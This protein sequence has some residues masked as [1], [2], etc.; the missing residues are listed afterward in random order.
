MSRKVCFLD[1]RDSSLNVGLNTPGCRGCCKSSNGVL[2]TSKSGFSGP[3]CVALLLF[4][5]DLR[6][7][8][9]THDTVNERTSSCGENAGINVL[10]IFPKRHSNQKALFSGC[11]PLE[12]R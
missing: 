11:A 12:V 8:V 3:Q 5:L 2:L 9:T 4:K 6:V 1:D 10:P 7:R